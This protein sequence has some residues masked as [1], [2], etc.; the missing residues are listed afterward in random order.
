MT[1]LADIA[2]AVAI[3]LACAGCSSS[4]PASSAATPAATAAVDAVTP[5]SFATTTI[6]YTLA[7]STASLHVEVASSPEQGERGLGYR[8]ALPE[9]SGMLFDLHE[10]RIPQFWM[11]GMRF[12][13]AHS[14]RPR[15]AKCGP[16]PRRSRRA[17][18][19]RPW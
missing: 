13:P 15:A 12:S 3:G 16:V 9:D 17:E 2:L 8:D 6:T 7:D 1:R 5:V 10:T 14:G 11:K 18:A 19:A 4:G